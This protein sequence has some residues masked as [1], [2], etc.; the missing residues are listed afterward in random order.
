MIPLDRL[1]WRLFVASC[2]FSVAVVAA[3]A[4]TVVA[5]LSLTRF[6]LQA[7]DAADG[8]STI[9]LFGWPLAGISHIADFAGTV[10][11]GWLAFAVLAEVFALRGLLVH[12][13]AFAGV[14]AAVNLLEPAATDGAVRFAAAIGFVAGFAHWLIA[15]RTAGFRPTTRTLAPRPPGDAP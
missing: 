12:L 6:G 13:V 9:A 2:G 10:F 14:A 11:A 7:G 15:G 1:L 5:A 8:G 4:A 3:L